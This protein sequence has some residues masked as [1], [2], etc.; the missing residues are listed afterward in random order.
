MSFEPLKPQKPEAAAVVRA[1]TP[2]LRQWKA[3]GGDLKALARLV[4][5]QLAVAEIAR[6][7]RIEKLDEI[8]RRLAALE[9]QQKSVRGLSYRGVWSEQEEYGVGDFVTDRG[10]VWAAKSASKGMRPGSNESWQLAV[11]AGRR[12][13][14]GR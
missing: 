3:D 5:A 9:E 14:D 11:K 4:C 6:K 13:R 10:S 8:D 2:L 12:G 7:W 1:A